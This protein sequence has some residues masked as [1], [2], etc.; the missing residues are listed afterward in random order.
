MTSIEDR[1]LSIGDA[2]ACLPGTEVENMCC[3]PVASVYSVQ[4]FWA[5]EEGGVF[6]MVG[7][8]IAATTSQILIDF[9]G[10]LLWG[11]SGRD[12]SKNPVS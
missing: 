11:S 2:A 12:T 7:S 4:G 6:T 9:I 3:V 10:L 8:A 5:N 1:I